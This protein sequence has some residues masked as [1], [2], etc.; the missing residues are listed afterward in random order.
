MNK[1]IGCA[2]F[3]FL[4]PHISKDFLNSVAKQ[5]ESCKDLVPSHTAKGQK[6]NNF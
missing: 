3:S 1:S 4:L 2:L 6:L 5:K